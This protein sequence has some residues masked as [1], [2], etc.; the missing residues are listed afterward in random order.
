MV[1]DLGALLRELVDF[2]SQRG[3]VAATT[4]AGRY[5]IELRGREHAFKAG[6]RS[7]E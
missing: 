4:S 1:G 7:I 5:Q 2:S 3:D 6:R